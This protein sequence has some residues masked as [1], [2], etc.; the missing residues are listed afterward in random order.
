M[1]TSYGL[2]I[3]LLILGMALLLPIVLLFAGQSWFYS[4]DQIESEE[5]FL[6][7][8][9]RLVIQQ[10][11]EQLTHNE[12]YLDT[13]SH[14]TVGLR[15][16]DQSECQRLLY[17]APF[18]PE[19][20]VGLAFY[21][22]KGDL[23]CAR[24]APITAD[25]S[26]KQALSRAA[27]APRT[28]SSDSSLTN[29]NAAVPNKLLLIQPLAPGQEKSKSAPDTLLLVA[30]INLS[31]FEQRIT[32]LSAPRKV[33]FVLIDPQG[34]VLSPQRLL[35]RD[36]HD[37]ALFSKI[38]GITDFTSFEATG[39]DGLTRTFVAAPIKTEHANL[40]YAWVT[41]PT[42]N[43]YWLAIRQFLSATALA[44][45]AV[46]AL[47][48]L[49]W[50]SNKRWV[51]QP[52][53]KLRQ[54]TRRIG[55]GDFSA[56]TGLPHTQD[57][58]GRLAASIDDMAAT[59]EKSES[60]RNLVLESA[61]LGAWD[62]DLLAGTTYRTAQHNRIFGY[63]TPQ[64]T[65]D[66]G[67]FFKHVPAEDQALVRQR[68]ADALVSGQHDLEI[69]II[70]AD[71][72][73]RWINVRGQVL[74]DEQKRPIR[75]IGIVADITDRKQ[76]EA[77][78]K[79]LNRTLQLLSEANEALLRIRNEHDLL[80]AIC[81]HITEIGGYPMAWVGFAIDDDKHILPV[82]QSGD[83]TILHQLKL[84]WH[85]ANIPADCPAGATI[86]TG[87]PVVIQDLHDQGNVQ[88]AYA[89]TISLP[90][91][92]SLGVMGAL[93]IYAHE[94]QAF[95]TAEITL[96]EKLANNLAYGI[97]HLREIHKREYFEQQLDYQSHFDRSTGLP[98]RAMFMKRLEQNISK[99]NPSPESG[100]TMAVIV[101]DLDR[102]KNFNDTLGHHIGDQLVQQMSQ[103]LA[104]ALE[105]NHFMGRLSVDE[106][107]IVVP[108][109]ASTAQVSEM[110]ARLL[111]HI[112]KPVLLAGQQL[113][114]TAS[115]GICL[116]PENGET[117]EALLQ[118]A[119]AAMY[120]SKARGGNT[121]Q[122]YVTEMNR[123]LPRRMMLDAALRQ[124]VELKQLQLLFQPKVSLHTGKIVG[125][126]ALLRWHHPELGMI[127]PVDFIPLAEE[128]GL[129]VSIGEWVIDDTCRQMRAWLDAGLKTP[130]VAV[131]LS[132]RQFVQENLCQMV[133]SILE[134]H[135]LE[136]S[137]LV[138][139]VTE[140][141]AMQDVE[142][143]IAIL[144]EL[145]SIGVKLSLDDFG[146]GYSSLSYLKRLPLDHLKID[147]A[148]VNDITQDPDDAAI[149]VAVIGLGH[150]LKMTVVAE[151]VETPEQMNFL[152]Q[153][154]CNEMQGYLF[155]RPVSSSDYEAM[156]Q[157]GK[158]QDLPPL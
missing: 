8:L 111:A 6:N 133:R 28:G 60:W 93:S 36:L 89:S 152:R 105:P 71:N 57:E 116:H 76:A 49:I 100:S 15:L 37:H 115:A 68:Y 13:L 30:Q 39:L 26:F 69:R 151:G 10:T 3:R 52:I 81:R 23:L 107:G 140:S 5:R 157:T 42:Q 70:R 114:V 66:A 139:E 35:G 143:A 20:L 131:N 9:A 47:L 104:K 138:L 1:T 27:A 79:K 19:S 55:E 46:I 65:A 155:S 48:A 135:R 129:I 141:T 125:A 128:T 82:A 61:K 53:D 50:H 4:K 94:A 87:L 137:M 2:R 136:P 45:L 25:A 40:G 118:C 110:V 31:W 32:D 12:S 120:G 142:R 43:P 24:G 41:L 84:T 63:D 62:I 130:P 16:I 113:Y 154:Q 109:P 108:S 74:Y 11:A 158:H 98:N 44:L 99:A 38:S 18:A 59:L 77:E 22:N 117:A 54:S 86:H 103:R 102:F 85:E 58:I 72:V 145:K 14:S 146:T 147:R 121:V 78:Q 56:R 83:D 17:N 80:E 91:T 34:K 88:A 153:H 112:A 64:L 124:A 148:F 101:V 29:I 97:E 95:D 127:S 149:C 122:V 92:N 119:Y 106:F 67:E 51:L 75:M 144:D 126:E 134:R 156:L 7:D 96:L 33:S 150:N 21:T 123:H 132:A 90:L 73:L